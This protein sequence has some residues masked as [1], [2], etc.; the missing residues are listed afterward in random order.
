[1]R[2]IL[3]LTTILMV[4]TVAALEIEGQQGY[5]LLRL[6]EWSIET[7]PSLAVITLLAV[8]WLMQFTIHLLMR[9][10]HS[11]R[12]L[13]QWNQKQRVNR[14]RKQL[15]RGLITLAEGE[16][17]KA[18]QLLSKSA[19]HSETPLMHYLGAANAAQ[20]LNDDEGRDRY[21]HLAHEEA[22]KA[23]F[24]I[25][26][27]Q[28][29]QQLAH[30]QYDAANETLQQLKQERPNQRKL[31]KLLVQCHHALEQWEELLRLLPK[32]RKYRVFN[33]D[34][35]QRLELE[36]ETRLL[37]IQRTEG[38]H[39]ALV[40]QWNRLSKQQRHNPVLFY[41]YITEL[42]QVGTYEEC[43]ALLQK[44]INYRWS[45]QLVSLYGSF[46]IKEAEQ[47]LQTA[48]Q[49]LSLHEQS[50]ALHLTIGRLFIRNEVWG[51]AQHHLE[52]SLEIEP[53]STAYQELAWLMK[54]NND[55][56]AAL[57]FA[58]QE[59]ALL[60]GGQPQPQLPV[61]YLPLAPAISNESE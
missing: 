18:E 42:L 39:G 52:R 13:K 53:S 12:D 46:T 33:S 50:A 38:G 34:E 40:K 16:W 37:T 32:L 17:K 60:R 31:L 9:F 11:P 47:Q 5:I 29:E 15:N 19:R 51:A 44:E 21:L 54:H 58:E 7:S 57:H 8:F 43:E 10:I 45:E 3:V 48:Q 36:A 20:H 55:L 35:L 61:N 27:T 24:V 26:L 1:M 41:H 23:D 56:T 49:W 28:A 25:R 59:A 4:V 6:G 22:P 2:R 14:A 30:Q